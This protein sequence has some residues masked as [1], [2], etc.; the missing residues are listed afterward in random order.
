MVGSQRSQGSGSGAR[1]SVG[2]ET[3]AVVRVALISEGKVA[4]ELFLRESRDVSVGRQ[5]S[6]TLRSDRRDLP[7]R[8]DLLL[9]EP[10][11]WFLALPEDP[12]ALKRMGILC[13]DRL[14]E[15]E[16]G[17]DCLRRS[18][19]ADPGQAEAGRMREILAE[20]RP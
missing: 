13:L 11:G 16:K 14:G 12:E 5:P 8:L 9:C 3:P 6:C 20:G 15:G 2:H 4:A 19:E 17:L 10:D 1:A 7:D 18:L